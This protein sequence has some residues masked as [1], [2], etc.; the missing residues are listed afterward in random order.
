MSEALL[1]IVLLVLAGIAALGLWR[2]RRSGYRF[3]LRTLLSVAAFVSLSLFVAIE[4]VLPA[5]ERH[6]AIEVVRRSH[7]EFYRARLNEDGLPEPI[8]VR[9]AWDTNEFVVLND[10]AAAASSA[11]ALG[12][13]P[14]LKSI[15]FDG[16]V[17][18][19]G[20]RKII[21]P[22]PA[23][24]PLSLH[25]QCPQMTD[26]ALA[27]IAQMSGLEELFFLSSGISDEA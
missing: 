25:F 20:I 27:D 8:Y 17:T 19:A 7:G 23:T 22:R 9:S 4:F 21:S 1:L 15:S 10:D 5:I 14:E 18:D 3:R 2:L 24:A 13:I 12:Q 11:A 16:G 6:R 26:A